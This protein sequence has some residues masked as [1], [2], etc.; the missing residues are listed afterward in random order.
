MELAERLAD[1]GR[2]HFGYSGKIIHRISKDKEYL[3]DS[4]NR[5]CPDITK[6]RMQLG[7]APS[8]GLDEG[9]LRTMCWYSENLQE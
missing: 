9:L 8:I 3:T 5:R 1:I 2:K 6:A 7:Y 4:P